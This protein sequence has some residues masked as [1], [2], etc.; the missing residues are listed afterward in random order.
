MK[1]LTFSLLAVAMISFTILLSSCSKEGPAGPAGATGPTGPTGPAGA[2]GS[3]GTANVIY[4]AWLDV[5]FQNGLGKIYAPKL[6]NDILNSG[7]IKVYWNPFTA[8]D[9]LVVPIP[10]VL[11][12][13]FLLENPEA[14]DPDVFVDPYFIQDSIFLT[15]NYNLTSVNGASRF[16][17]I[18]I[19]GGATA[20]K[21]EGSVDVDWNNYEAVK[22]YLKLED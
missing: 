6:T 12:I 4:S 19:P 14:N 9:P 13:G 16:R 3:V 10:C 11:P 7:D 8:A 2:A 15:A 1:R 21:K 20:R 18:L 22:N 5:T 17:Y